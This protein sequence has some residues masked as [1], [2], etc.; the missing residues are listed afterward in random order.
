MVRCDEISAQ[1]FEQA[2]AD[3]VEF[4][5]PLAQGEIIPDFGS[6]VENRVSSALGESRK[7]SSFRLGLYRLAIRCRI[8]FPAQHTLKD[9][10]I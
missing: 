6:R 7:L 10:P 5:K 3:L 9:N 8:R 1:A 4:N 2:T